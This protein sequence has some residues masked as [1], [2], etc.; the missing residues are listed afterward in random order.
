MAKNVTSRYDFQQFDGIQLS[1]FPSID[2]NDLQSSDDFYIKLQYGQRIDTLAYQYLGDGR[3]WWIICLLNGLR[4]PF[5][6]SLITGKIL[7]IP[8]SIAPI[9]K[10]LEEKNVITN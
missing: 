4:T 5:D 9:I 10:T 2:P 8:T 6:K 1:S 7:R 3:Y